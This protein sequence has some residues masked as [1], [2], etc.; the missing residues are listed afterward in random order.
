MIDPNRSRRID[1]ALLRAA[2]LCQDDLG[3]DATLLGLAT[4]T[5]I[6]DI[7]KREVVDALKRL[8]PKYLTLC[9]IRDRRPSVFGVSIA[10]HR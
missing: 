2:V 7:E 1:Y 4:L 10:N 6:P 5:N 8:R 9:K 3:Y